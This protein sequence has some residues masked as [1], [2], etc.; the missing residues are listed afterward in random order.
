MQK[1]CVRFSDTP[2]CRLRLTFTA[3]PTSRCKAFVCKHLRVFEQQ[4]RTPF[5]CPFFGGERGIRT[6]GRLLA[7]HTISRC[8]KPCRRGA[9]CS[10]K[11]AYL[12]VELSPVSAPVK[13]NRAPLDA[14]LK[15]HNI[16][17]KG[18]FFGASGAKRR[19][20]N[21]PFCRRRDTPVSRTRLHR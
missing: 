18:R 20:E 9:V 21:R 4:K 11:G 8:R 19:L 1:S 5:R 17:P 10:V 6:L 14:Y 3:T 12:P 16:A 13:D 15:Q 2:R 7:E